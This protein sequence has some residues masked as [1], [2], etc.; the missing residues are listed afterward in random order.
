MIRSR[1]ASCD[2]RPARNTAVT[3]RGCQA[4]IRAGLTGSPQRT[5]VG[6]SL[7]CATR[8]SATARSHYSSGQVGRVFRFAA[9]ELGWRGQDPTRLPERADGPRARRGHGGA[10]FE[11]HQREELAAL[12]AEHLRAPD[13]DRWY[14]TKAAATY[15]GIHPDT[16]RTVAAQRRIRFR[17]E[18]PGTTL[19]F[20]R[21]WL[22]AYRDGTSK[23][24]HRDT[25]SS[26]GPARVAFGQRRWN[27][28]QAEGSWLNL[29]QAIRPGAH[30]R[31]D[32]R[33]RS[34]AP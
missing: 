29:Q 10:I 16:L 2:L 13:E 12:V 28:S 5:C 32:A 9:A 4:G 24:R 7:G 31:S 1:R 30:A 6:C 8:G 15:L 3:L 33:L 23:L 18:R 34:G 25:A 21:S 19:H 22:D 17:Q 26:F 14:K 11:G 27:E 20:K